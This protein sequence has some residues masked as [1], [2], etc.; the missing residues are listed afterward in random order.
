MIELKENIDELFMNELFKSF[1]IELYNKMIIKLKMSLYAQILDFD[2]DKFEA[3]LNIKVED[4]LIVEEFKE[5]VLKK[6]VDLSN[7][8]NEKNSYSELVQKTIDYIDT[9]FKKEITVSDLAKKIYI[10]PRYLSRIFNRE[11]GYGIPKYINELK[12]N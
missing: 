7:H 11:V 4:F 8:I 10:S 6:L 1:D 5:E 2:Y 3:M 12:L 9:N